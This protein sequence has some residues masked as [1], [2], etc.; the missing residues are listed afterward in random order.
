MDAVQVKRPEKTEYNIEDAAQVLLSRIDEGLDD[1]E[2]GRVISSEE[3]WKEI[4]SND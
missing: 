1:Y 2:N 3:M 4:D